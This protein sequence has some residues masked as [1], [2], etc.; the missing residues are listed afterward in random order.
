MSRVRHLTQHVVIRTPLSTQ[1]RRLSEPGGQ[2]IKFAKRDFDIGFEFSLSN[3][4]SLEVELIEKLALEYP[5]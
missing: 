2:I 1:H 3:T 5:P 4:R